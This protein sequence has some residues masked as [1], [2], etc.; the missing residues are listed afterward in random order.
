MNTP[1][2]FNTRDNVPTSDASNSTSTFIR[3]ALRN[4]SP[5]APPRHD[6]RINHFLD[7]NECPPPPTLPDPPQNRRAS[8]TRRYPTATSLESLLADRHA[9]DPSR[10]IITAGGDEAIDRICR[11]CLD[12]AADHEL[13]LPSPSFEMIARY[14]R[15]ANANIITPPWF[16]GQFPLNQIL[17][18]CTPRTKIIAV[19]S[20]NNPTGGTITRDQLLQLANERP[21]TLLMVDLAYTEFADEDLTPIAAALPNSVLIRTFSKA[22]GCAGLRVG[23]AIGPRTVINAMRA[24]ASPFPVA[25]TSLSTI[26]SLLRGETSWITE[27]VA[28]VRRERA[29]LI[30]LLR[31]L[32]IET[33]DSQANFVLCR[34]VAADAIKTALAE[35]GIAIRAYSPQSPLASCLRITCPANESDQSRLVA[36][37]RFAITESAPTAAANAAPSPTDGARP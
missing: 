2:T 21:D 6:P 12:P 22:W 8:T 4:L 32:N 30:A 26:E 25:G 11:A 36:A 35:Q 34:T 28:R 10:I 16:G 17:S 27:R 13:I 15:L 5:Y 33:L 7:A 3:P 37:L 9:I 18:A 23:Y 29:E 24:V 14:A 1:T 31:S 19:V 20:P